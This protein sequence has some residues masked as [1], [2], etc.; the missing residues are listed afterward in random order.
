M[1]PLGGNATGWSYSVTCTSKGRCSSL[2]PSAI[3]FSKS[4]IRAM[5]AGTS[6]ARAFEPASTVKIPAMNLYSISHV[7]TAPK[8]S[9]IFG[10]I[11]L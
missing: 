5:G 9:N 4:K 2:G 8:K 10:Y 11:V 7:S 6:A 3:T 1:D